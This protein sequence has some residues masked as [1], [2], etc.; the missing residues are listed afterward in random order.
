[1]RIKG[2][3][4]EIMSE[5]RRKKEEEKRH[6]HSRQKGIRVNK[7]RNRITKVLKMRMK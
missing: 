1:M 2:V 7:R 5:L 3:E 6:T 4:I